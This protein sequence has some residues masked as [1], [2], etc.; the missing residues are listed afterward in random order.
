MKKEFS[1]LLGAAGLVVLAGL[2]S[3]TAQAASIPLEPPEAGAYILDNAKLITDKNENLIRAICDDLLARQ[4]MPLVVVTID[5]MERM[6]GPR[7]AIEDFARRLFDQWGRD[8]R[9]PYRASWRRGIILLVSKED[10]KARIELGAHWAGQYNVQSQR[11]M[12]Q[13]I[14]PAFKEGHFSRGIYQGVEGLE[15]MSRGVELPEWTSEDI[16]ALIG[17]AGLLGGLGILTY[18]SVK[19]EGGSRRSGVRSIYDDN[20]GR[21]SSSSSSSDSGGGGGATGS[22]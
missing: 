3:H 8:D 17:I 7:D 18:L 10:R 20:Y 22:W 2:L 5:S 21:S 16:E 14:I 11:V 12:D 9:F 19:L 4:E 13:L 15:A 6:G 1:N